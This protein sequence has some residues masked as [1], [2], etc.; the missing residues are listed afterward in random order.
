MLDAS[1]AVRPHWKR[2]WQ[3]VKNSSASQMRQRLQ[4]VQRQISENS[5]T[6]NVYADPQGVDRLWQLDLLPNLIPASEWQTLAAGIVQ[7]AQLLCW[8]CAHSKCRRM[9][10]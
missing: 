9:H 4:L 7:R 6:Y 1:G 2:L 5:V 10:K 3:V 8:N